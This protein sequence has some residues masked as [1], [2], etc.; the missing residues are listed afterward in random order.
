METIAEYG[1]KLKVDNT[2][3][4]K[5]IG[6]LRKEARALGQIGKEFSHAAHFLTAAV[7]APITALG[8]MGVKKYLESTDAGA[9]TL[10]SSL[11]SLS[12][13]WNQMLGRI[14]KV[15]VGHGELGKKVESL[16]H[17]LDSID[18]KKINQMLNLAK[19]AAMLATVLKITGEF[20]KWRSLILKME[21]N[22][23]IL[24]MLEAKRGGK[25]GGAGQGILATFGVG[26]LAGISKILSDFQ[27]GLDQGSLSLTRFWQIIPRLTSAVSRATI[28]VNNNAK[29]WS[30]GRGTNGRF[31]SKSDKTELASVTKEYAEGA[32][33]I[34]KVYGFFKQVGTFLSKMAKILFVFDMLAGLFRGLGWN[35]SSGL[36]LLWK[37]LMFVAD[38]IDWIVSLLASGFENFG[39]ILK[40]IFT[41]ESLEKMI[42]EIEKVQ[43]GVVDK[44][45]WNKG[46]ANEKLD[47]SSKGKVSSVGFADL[48]KS[49]Q[50]WAIQKDQKDNTKALKDNTEALKLRA[51]KIK[52]GDQV[53]G[54]FG[55]GVYNPGVSYAC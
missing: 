8:T 28:L 21:V 5:Q 43:Q 31:I 39:I 13:S 42:E 25:S 50:N 27:K 34:A 23:G 35:V 29:Y 15:I 3:F 36:D 44:R 33:S 1:I 7:V 4:K 12:E 40:G 38:T 6:D 30:Q 17:W 18:E 24:A 52:S 45:P 2:D 47:W 9:K 14:G 11:S 10:K 51:G 22:E 37:S 20:Y 26:G 19:W 54:I 55:G 16:K 32:E 46:G 53:A 49:A 41:G 48:N